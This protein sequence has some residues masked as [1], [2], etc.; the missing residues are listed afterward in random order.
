MLNAKK[1]LCTRLEIEGM[2]IPHHWVSD[3]NPGHGR[4]L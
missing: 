2:F 3:E 4:F 1:V